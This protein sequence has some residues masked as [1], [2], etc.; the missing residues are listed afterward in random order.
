[1]QRLQ[2]LEDP[3]HD[4]SLSELMKV[5]A[6]LEVPLVDLLEDSDSLARPIQERAKLV[7]IMKT[8]AA[9]EEAQL[10]IRPKRLV[11]MLREQLTDLM[12]ELA[13]VG[14][15][16]QFGSRR[17]ATSVARVLEREISLSQISTSD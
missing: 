10:S 13:Q 7:R 9:I 15:W 5:Q 3:T 12:P 8:V 11:A 2:E 16:P 1:M 14:S 17:G 4:I 6:A